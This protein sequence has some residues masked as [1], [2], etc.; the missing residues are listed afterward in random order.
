M[1][2]EWFKKT[3]LTFRESAWILLHIDPD[4]AGEDNQKTPYNTPRQGSVPEQ[5]VQHFND[6]LHG[7]NIMFRDVALG[8]IPITREPWNR[9]PHCF[10]RIGHLATWSQHDYPSNHRIWSDHGVVEEPL[11]PPPAE[12]IGPEGE[13]PVLSSMRKQMILRAATRKLKP[14]MQDEMSW[15][16]QWSSSTSHPPLTPP[17][18]AVKN[19]LRP[20]YKVLGKLPVLEA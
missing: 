9:F 7:L 13:D 20:L 1:K 3:S 12:W 18:V 16:H 14:M 19:A 15:L 2:S 4:D 5:I 8:I 10:I 17:L 11:P 6:Y